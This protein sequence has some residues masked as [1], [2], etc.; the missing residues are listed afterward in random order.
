MTI[1]ELL[2]AVT[3]PGAG[4]A[5][6]VALVVLTS[7]VEVSPLR[8]NPWSAIAKAVG[9]ALNGEVIKKMDDLS[10]EVRQLEQ[11]VTNIQDVADERAADAARRDIL[12]FADS[13]LHYTPHSKDSFD[14]ILR[15]CTEYERYCEANSSYKNNV[16]AS[17][18]HLIM[19]EYEKCMEENSFLN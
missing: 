11:R 10:T 16:T 2:S 4:G 1:S 12:N 17:S 19:K 7:L 13:L 6:L 9:R 15:R 18:I 5:I 8:I 14:D 3:A